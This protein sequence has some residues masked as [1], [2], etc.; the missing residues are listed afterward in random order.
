M[1]HAVI[2]SGLALVASACGG[3]DLIPGQTL[4]EVPASQVTG[5]ASTAPPDTPV[6]ETTLIA[7]AS[8]TGAGAPWSGT[9]LRLDQ[10]PQILIN[11]WQESEVKNFCSALYPADPVGDDATIRSANFSGGWAVA[12][13]LPDGKG[14][15]ASGEYCEDCGR[16][17]VGIAGTFGPAAGDENRV[18]SK[19]LTWPDGSKAGYGYEGFV[20]E[21]SEGQPHLMYL[22][23]KGEGCLYN[24][25]SFL[26]EEHLV[27]LVND[28]RLV[29]ALRGEPTLWR[30]EVPAP[31]LQALGEPAWVSQDPLTE[32]DIS[33]L[34][35]LEWEG[36]AG[37]PNSCPLL[38]FK[39]LGDVQIDG[40][41]RRADSSGEML[42]A[43][44]R[45]FGPGHNGFSQPCQDCGR[46][47]VGLGTFQFSQI[48]DREIT[49]EWS[50]GSKA[51]AFES[52]YGTELHL[53]P[54]GFDC[55][56]WMW[57]HLGREHVDYLLTQLRRVEG[58][59]PPLE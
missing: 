20:S 5:T 57:S 21:G 58:Y 31:P 55:I 40:V 8:G 16:G 35:L 25:W 30:N 36:E 39:N 19:Q 23:V 50:D 56:Y 38:A 44:D 28:L 12:W 52:F 22:L 11:Q 13:D 42:L 6:T 3:G 27:G 29:E 43:W 54:A 32:S 4:P 17:A 9:Q 41:V 46:G 47:V 49:H 24:I 48:F 14:R 7:D 15:S 26:G 10:V 59:P 45:T 1:R 53:Q 18:W 34:Y 51:A 37:A 2:V 33:E